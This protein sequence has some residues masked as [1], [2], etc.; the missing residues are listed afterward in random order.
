MHNQKHQTTELRDNEQEEE[1][2]QSV[3]PLKNRK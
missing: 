3:I 1:E 2:K